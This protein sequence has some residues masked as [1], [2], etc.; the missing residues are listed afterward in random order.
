M[1]FNFLNLEKEAKLVEYDTWDHRGGT[2]SS[3]G[4]FGFSSCENTLFVACKKRWCFSAQRWDRPFFLWLLSSH[5]I[6]SRLRYGWL[7]IFFKSQVTYVVNLNIHVLP[8][9]EFNCF[10]L[11]WDAPA[12]TLVWLYGGWR[13]VKM[14]T[15]GKFFSVISCITYIFKCTVTLI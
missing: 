13:L 4:I 11:W 12:K 6:L 10:C 14:N 9:A 2:G 5:F 15:L 8:I 3:L 7:F 1:V